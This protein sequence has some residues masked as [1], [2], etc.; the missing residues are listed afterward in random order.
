MSNP[1][2]LLVEDNYDNM[3]LMKMLIEHSSKNVVTALDGKQGLFIAKTQPPDL[4]IL[5]LDMP[6]MNGWDMMKELKR[7][8]AL[9]NIPVLVVT[10]HLLPN[11]RKKVIDAGGSG[12]VS[13]PFR[14]TEFLSEIENCLA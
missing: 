2:I 4:I 9:K 1:T 10:A 6:V 11:E 5:D 8:P 12:Y 13:K 3:T 7:D 14:I